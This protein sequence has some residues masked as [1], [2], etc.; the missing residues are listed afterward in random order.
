VITMKKPY[1]W[2]GYRK[3][4]RWYAVN[5]LSELDSPGEWY[6]ERSTGMLYFWPPAS[7]KDHSAYVS[8]IDSIIEMEN[9]SNVS[10]VNL[11]LEVC[12]GK[13]VTIRGGENNR[14]V[15]CLIRNTGTSAVDINGGKNNGVQSCDLQHIGETVISVQGGDRKTLTPAGHYVDNC[16]IQDY[17]RWVYTYRS[18][19]SVT[20][21][22]NRIAHN[23]I[24]NAPHNAIGLSGNEHLIEFNEVHHVCQE[25]DDAGAFYMGRD[26]TQRGNVIRHNYWHHIGD[27]KSWI[28]VQAVY[29]DD[30][31]S[32]T[33][34][35][36]NVFYRTFR[37]I[38]IG[39]GRDNIV[40]NNLFAEC[41]MGV[42]I[43]ARGMGWAKNYFDGSYNVLAERL[44][45]MPYRKPPW[46]ERYPEL[47]TLYDDEP[48]KP[49]NNIVTSNISIGPGWLEVH[50][51]KKLGAEVLTVTDNLAIQQD[52]KNGGVTDLFTA[53]NTSEPPDGFHFERIPVEKI[54]LYVDEYRKKLPE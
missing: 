11:I 35:F 48:A 15:G 2:Y 6:L 43:D 41:K 36:G 33:T 37:G 4:A 9:V 25:T 47:L 13:A 20:G 7:V 12:R 45:A 8:L 1:H 29:L 14:L 31:S 24:H 30:F 27:Y 28:G 50:M 51:N 40:K 3:G 18:A 22:G 46:S 26:Y 39:G 42:Y 53:I 54:G 17:S 10:F 52:D 5:L 38:L 23:L 19:V 32:G 16:H 34:I 44:E 21:V 49:K